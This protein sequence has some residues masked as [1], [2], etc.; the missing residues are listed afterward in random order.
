MAV[1]ARR[2]GRHWFVAFKDE[3]LL[4][5]QEFCFLLLSFW[6]S[7]L[8]AIQKMNVSLRLTRE[9]AI[10]LFNV[11]RVFFLA[12]DYC[13]TDLFSLRLKEKQLILFIGAFR[14]L[15]DFM[16]I[17]LW[18]LFKNYLF[19]FNFIFQDFGMPEVIGPVVFSY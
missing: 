4:C 11:P 14:S 17:W 16:W 1:L 13:V 18:N 7:N 9:V 12:Y 15:L 10:F 8:Y 19:M 2:A 6:T 5:V 3:Q